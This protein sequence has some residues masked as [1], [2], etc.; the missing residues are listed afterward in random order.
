MFIAA[1][2]DAFPQYSA[3]VI[4]AIRASG[5]DES[6]VSLELET[7][8]DHGLQGSRFLVAN[9]QE[10]A[11]HHTHFSEIKRRLAESRL[12]ASV[13][14]HAL[15]IFQLLAEAEARIH[16]KEVDKVA[17]H[18]VGAWD[19]IA[20]VV[21]AALLIDRLG[22]VQWFCDP[23][24][25][26]RG[27][28]ESAHGTLPVPAPATALL[29]EGMPTFSDAHMGERV[30]PTGAA[31]LRYLSPAFSPHAG[32]A[33][34]AASGMGFGSRRF[35]GMANLLRVLVFEPTAVDQQGQ[36][37]VVEFEV[38]DQSAEELAAGLEHLRHTNGVFDVLQQAVYAKK[39][40][41]ATHVRILCAVE[42]IEDVAHACFT[43]TTTLGVRWQTVNR[44]TL[45]RNMHEYHGENGERIRVKTAAR[46]HGL[47]AKA[48]LD[49]VTA[50]EDATQ[51]RR[52]R[53]EA[54]MAILQQAGRNN[55]DRS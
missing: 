47:S 44:L 41:L 42:C 36:V 16:D 22:D 1:M 51:R 9:Q 7:C 32:T 4:E 19:S 8:N 29:M 31:I 25:L 27:T 3:A 48:E 26:G 54:E 55:E 30:T 14:K 21:G 11:H 24:P 20:D 43:Q 34:L 17:F 5:L 46:P 49:D 6:Q 38:D 39:A 10:S 45:A 12:P 28:V 40:R 13:V 15:G 50:A 52:K 53:I 37:G 2:L 23:L 18:E 35:E 33:R